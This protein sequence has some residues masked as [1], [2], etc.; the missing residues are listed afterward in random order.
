[1][2]G[3]PMPHIQN[4]RL[5]AD[6]EFQRFLAARRAGAIMTRAEWAARDR[7]PVPLWRRLLGMGA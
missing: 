6:T 3:K 2:E 4:N 5:R 1:M 7:S